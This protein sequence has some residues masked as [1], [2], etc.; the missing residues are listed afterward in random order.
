MSNDPKLKGKNHCDLN[1]EFVIWLLNFME[2]TC[3]VAFRLRKRAWNLTNEH[4]P[5]CFLGISKSFLS[6]TVESQVA[7]GSCLRVLV[8]LPCGGTLAAG[9]SPWLGR[10]LW[11]DQRP[12]NMECYFDVQLVS[13]KLI[14]LLKI[15]LDPK[16]KD[17]LPFAHF[18][19]G[20]TAGDVNIIEV[21]F[22]LPGESWMPTFTT[23]VADCWGPPDAIH[24]TA[25]SHE[26]V[27]RFGSWMFSKLFGVWLSTLWTSVK[28]AVHLFL[29]LRSWIW[30]QRNGSF[31][32]T[33][34]NWSKEWCGD[35][36]TQVKD[37][38]NW[39][40]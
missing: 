29:N 38:K 31:G 32:R 28:D 21:V 19:L 3:K 30:K 33:G 14:W 24:Q 8:L 39:C 23:G 17:C 26:S 16:V 10:D 25:S 11:T 4:A 18:C 2:G 5:I 20:R 7:L 13:L 22:T 27:G 34:D 37:T 40:F 12:A 15:D 1:L 6:P 9:D 35:L 36:V